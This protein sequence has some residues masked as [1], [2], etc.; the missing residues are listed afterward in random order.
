MQQTRQHRRIRVEHTEGTKDDDAAGAEVGIGERAQIDERLVDPQLAPDQQAQTQREADQQGLHPP[1]G[2]AEPVPFLPLA[3]EDLPAD[4]GQDQQTQAQAIE[5]C[6]LAVSRRPLRLEIV[7]V[8]DNRAAQRQG[9]QSA[10]DVQEEDPAPADMVGEIT[11][12][13]RPD[14]RREQRGDPEQGHGG[15]LLLGR[16]GIEKHALA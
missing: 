14:D 7:R 8:G 13:R 10:R 16:E 11:A 6:P 12:E 15:A 3:Q 9:E 2:V 4:H 1:E 5:A